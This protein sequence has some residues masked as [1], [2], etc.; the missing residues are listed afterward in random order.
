MLVSALVLM[1]VVRMV[2]WDKQLKGGYRL[3]NVEW[4]GI[5]GENPLYPVISKRPYKIQTKEKMLERLPMLSWRMRSSPQNLT[6][7]PT[8]LSFSHS[9]MASEALTMSFPLQAKKKN[10]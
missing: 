7:D 5:S 1:A 3:L 9:S 6:E 4:K 2:E 8:N 10:S